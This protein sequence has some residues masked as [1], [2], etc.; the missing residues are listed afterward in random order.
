MN[1]EYLTPSMWDTLRKL[2]YSQLMK[3][4]EMMQPLDENEDY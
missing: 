2:D 1:I 4:R 3:F